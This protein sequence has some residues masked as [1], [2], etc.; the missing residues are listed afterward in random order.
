M[1]NRHSGQTCR[2]V[3]SRGEEQFQHS[4]TSRPVLESEEEEWEE[5]E[6]CRGGTRDQLI[7]SLISGE[8][9]SGM[10]IWVIE[11]LRDG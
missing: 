1:G 7:S 9:S 5:E 11:S 8:V 4:P 10:E 2:E 3:A 6:V